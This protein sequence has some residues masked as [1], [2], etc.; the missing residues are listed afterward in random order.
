MAPR[1]AEE[2]ARLRD[3]LMDLIRAQRER[4]PSLGYLAHLREALDYRYWHRFSV[5]AVDDARPGSMRVLSPRLGLSQGEQRVLSYLALFAAAA[6]HF[7][8]L[9]ASCPRLLL[10]DEGRPAADRTRSRLRDDQRANVGV[11]S[12]SAEPRD[13]RSP[14]RT[15]GAGCGTRAFPVGRPPAPPDRDVRG[16]GPWRRSTTRD[17]SGCGMCWPDGCSAMAWLSKDR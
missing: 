16:P 17:L 1:A 10:L 7:D 13:L 8:G 15:L 5:Q 6:A 14:A 11:L 9:G 4:D 12:R 2:D 3:A